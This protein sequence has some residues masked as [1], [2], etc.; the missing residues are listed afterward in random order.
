MFRLIIS[1]ALLL[2]AAKS[3]TFYFGDC[4]VKEGV[5]ACNPYNRSPFPS[6]SLVKL[7]SH[8]SESKK[9]YILESIKNTFGAKS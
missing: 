1:A 5:N 4:L 9:K 3:Q 8:I 7:K 2:T 6:D